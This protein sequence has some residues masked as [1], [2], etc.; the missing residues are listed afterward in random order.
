MMGCL[1]GSSE[2]QEAS[3]QE[4]QLQA[5]ADEEW[6]RFKEQYVPVEEAYLGEIQQ[7]DSPE[8]RR[9]M[10]AEQ[11]NVAQRANTVQP[12]AGL[13]PNSG[14]GFA[15]TLQRGL[16]TGQNA[17]SGA[18]RGDLAV[19]SRKLAGLQSSIALG[20]G[21][22]ENATV[23]LTR[24]AQQVAAANQAAALDAAAASRSNWNAAGQAAGLGLGA[25]RTFQQPVAAT[26]INP[27]TTQRTGAPVT[28]LNPPPT[29]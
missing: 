2:K 7:F 5:I 6:A 16:D 11:A 26:G 22:K 13:D 20:R 17:A 15:N 1:G 4:V 27:L 14:A 18:M 8:E 24:S 21:I 19:D 23:N 9:D 25:Y 12:Q 3:P 10:V 28:D 29:A